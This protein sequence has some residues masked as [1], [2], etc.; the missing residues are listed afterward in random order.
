[1]RARYEVQFQH[2][3]AANALQALRKTLPAIP[4]QR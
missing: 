4:P 3:D 1:V 2:P